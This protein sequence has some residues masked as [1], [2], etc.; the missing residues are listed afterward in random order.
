MD[1]IH[2][3]FSQ[4]GLAFAKCGVVI[5]MKS[6][7]LFQTY[8]NNGMSKGF[9]HIQSLLLENQELLPEC[10]VIHVGGTNGKGST[11]TFL[12]ES[13]RRTGNTVITFTSPHLFEVNE[14]I[15]T[16]NGNI[17]DDEIISHLKLLESS[18]DLKGLTFFEILFLIYLHIVKSLKPDYA[19]IE[20]GLGGRLDTTNVIQK[21][22]ACILTSISLDHMAIL[23]DNTQSIALDKT[24]IARKGTPLYIPDNIKEIDLI[25]KE[26]QKIGADLK[27]VKPLKIEGKDIVFGTNAALAYEVLKD[28]GIAPFQSKELCNI[29]PTGRLQPISGTNLAD[30]CHNH[31]GALRL[32]DYL[33]NH[34][35][36]KSL[37]FCLMRDKETETVSRL[38]LKRLSHL[39]IH[40]VELSMERA[41]KWHELKTQL[42]ELANQIHPIEEKELEQNAAHLKHSVFCGSF[43]L[44][45]HISSLF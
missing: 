9:D 22:A 38:F 39:K 30:V 19:V 28:L 44:M 15:Q 40:F 32:C 25:K 2:S 17:S 35:E 23:G 8:L 31:A 36:Y 33:E 12:H 24:G 13:L 34:P 16:E 20:V 45:E 18:L 21:K 5:A 10:P 37:Y 27:I 42:G 41:L 43:H 4:L 29:S 26:A 11:C 7:N 6:L 14:R 1:Y 3:Q